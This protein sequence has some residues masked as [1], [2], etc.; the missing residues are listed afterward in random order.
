MWGN[1]MNIKRHC[2]VAGIL[3]GVSSVA[4]AQFPSGLLKSIEDKVK[5]VEK[6]VQAPSNGPDSKLPGAPT[7]QPANPIP[8]AAPAVPSCEKGIWFE[9]K[10][11]CISS[12]NVKYVSKWEMR[13]AGAGK[14]DDRTLSTLKTKCT[15]SLPTN[16]YWQ[17]RLRQAGI[18][19]DHKDLNLVIFSCKDEDDSHFTVQVWQDFHFPGYAFIDGVVIHIPRLPKI[20]KDLPIAKAL[21]SKYGEPTSFKSDARMD[22]KGTNGELILLISPQSDTS[23]SQLI[24]INTDYVELAKN[25]ALER[26]RKDLEEKKRQSEEQ[27][28]STVP[29][30]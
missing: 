28:T 25:M 4:L 19:R 21:I 6:N 8:Q 3:A 5:Q 18:P 9:S 24:F 26:R 12:E 13:G 15:P 29:K 23:T 10:N 22:W 16:T 2:V 20:T 7:P 30:L 1:S 27:A 14:L 11:S 17:D